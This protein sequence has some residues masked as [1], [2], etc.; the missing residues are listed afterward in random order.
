MT[1]YSFSVISVKILSLLFK[2]TPVKIIP[3]DNLEEFAA[4]MKRCVALATYNFVS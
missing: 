4:T 2:L 3:T 1:Q